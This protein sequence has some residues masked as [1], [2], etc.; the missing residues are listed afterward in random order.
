MISP[1][2]PIT[3]KELDLLKRNPL[4][5]K[6]ADFISKL[7]DKESLVIGIEGEWGSGKTSFIN[8]IIDKLKIND[9]SIIVKFNPWHFSNQNELVKDF[10]Y[11]LSSLLK[12]DDDPK[13]TNR[14]KNYVEKLINKN[15]INI[16]PEISFCG[17][18]IK[19]GEYK[20]INNQT[21][22]KQKEEID[23][24]LNEFDKKI[25]IIIDDI[26]RLD[27]E[28]TKLI[29][30]L[31]KLTANFSN[32]IFLLA[33]DR[34]KVANRI[35]EDGIPGEEYLKKIIQLGFTLPNP[36]PHDF[37]KILFNDID[38]IIKG[39]DNKYWDRT[40]WGNLFYSALKN[41]FLNIRD[42]KRY[43]NSLRLDLEIIKMEEIN[44]I[45][46]LGVEAIRVFAP[47]VYS[48]IGSNKETFIRLES[49]VAGYDT[50]G[51]NKS[52]KETIEKIIN[53]K[54]TGRSDEYKET[55]RELIKRLFPQ[56]DGLYSN[57]NYGYD[58]EKEWRLKLQVCSKDI[59]DK[60]F[61]LSIR[62]T[63]LSEVSIKELLNS[64]NDEVVFNKKM[65]ELKK[66]DKIRLILDRLPDHL[67]ELDENQ[68]KNLLI[69]IFNF[70]ETVEDKRRGA[71]D[72]QDTETLTLRL[73][74]QVLKTINSDKQKN[75]LETIMKSAKAIYPPIYLL[76]VLNKEFKKQ[77]D[78]EGPKEVSL[79][80]SEFK[81]LNQIGKRIIE[82]SAEK[83][84]LQ[85]NNNFVSLLYR[86]E[87]WGGKSKVKTFIE[88]LTNSDQGIIKYIKSF[89]SESF[90][91]GMGDYVSTSKKNINKKAIAN[92]CDIEELDKKID[93]LDIDKINPKDKKII[94]LYKNPINDNFGD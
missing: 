69:N 85:N 90:S 35:T 84:K 8:L 48:A 54:L 78:K 71:F 80:E 30:K 26:D 49:L 18:K 45:D 77:K 44:P 94:E 43:I 82:V 23:K 63:T 11:S 41:L 79:T 86:W 87:E 22:E 34:T 7:E 67:E 61:S 59:F 2:N 17:F 56:V 21:L 72:L 74:Y 92:F 24:L 46:F 32:T 50:S 13:K 14:I 16:I 57:M 10:F 93:K 65:E 83:N 1:D 39:G 20:P 88:I 89:I 4:A 81:A 6:I 58:W 25:V 68:K 70:L 47:D 75:F 28:E 51:E 62:S 27:S 55:I 60:Y 12:Q 38:K 15:E 37:Q 64:L 40:R 19:L 42:I 53:E 36:D 3:S 91:H 33:Y 9:K 31:V 29:F 66:D 76:A 5:E 73:S 52:R